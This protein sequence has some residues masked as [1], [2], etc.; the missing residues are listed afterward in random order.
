MSDKITIHATPTVAKAW[1]MVISC[2]CA[3]MCLCRALKDTWL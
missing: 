2:I 3:F 1:D